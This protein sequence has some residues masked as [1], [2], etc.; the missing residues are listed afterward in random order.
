MWECCQTSLHLNSSPECERRT[1]VEF[2]VETVP[3]LC[4]R[5]GEML[6]SG[7]YLK[8]IPFQQ[9]IYVLE[10]T[11]KYR[12]AM[13]TEMALTALKNTSFEIAMQRAV[14]FFFPLAAQTCIIDG[15]PP[16]SLALLLRSP[17]APLSRSRCRDQR[18]AWAADLQAVRSCFFSC[19]LPSTNRDHLITGT[20]TEEDL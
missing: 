4:K 10:D 9:L 2:L 19:I 13:L 1:G 3:S 5:V 12:V 8:V 17:C 14:P 16:S 7:M 15:L 6:G 18:G 20:E 11:A